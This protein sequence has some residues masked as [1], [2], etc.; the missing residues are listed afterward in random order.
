M[1]QKKN[2]RYEWQVWGI[3]KIVDMKD[4]FLTNIALKCRFE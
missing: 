3:L 2:D 1:V 4:L